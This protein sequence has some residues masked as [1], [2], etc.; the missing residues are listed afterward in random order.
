MSKFNLTEQELD[1][2]SY[3]TST[4]R[5]VYPIYDGYGKLCFY[6]ARAYDGSEPKAL[7]YGNKIY[8]TIGP[9]SDKLVIVED[10]I[11]AI[12]VGRYIQTFPLFG[13]SIKKEIIPQ[14]VDLNQHIFLWLDADKYKEALK[15][16]KMLRSRGKHTGVIYTK[17]D[18]KDLD[19]II[20]INRLSNANLLDSDSSST[21]INGT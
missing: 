20:I 9:K 11:S 10:I 21:T 16:A 8:H 1:L 18:P 19:D 6:Q 5:V 17:E 13:S 3:D 12:K 4:G 14:I 2:F 7:T 15:L